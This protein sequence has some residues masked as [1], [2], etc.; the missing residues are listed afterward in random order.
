M[1][2]RRVMLIKMNVDVVGVGDSHTNSLRV[3]NEIEH[4]LLLWPGC[5]LKLHHLERKKTLNDLLKTG[6][7]KVCITFVDSNFDE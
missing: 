1:R 4:L 3:S 2:R 5:I 7:I 6:I